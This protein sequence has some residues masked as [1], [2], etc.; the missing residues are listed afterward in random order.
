MPSANTVVVGDCAMRTP[1]ALVWRGRCPLPENRRRGMAGGRPAGCSARI[2]RVVLFDVKFQ[3][4]ATRL[5][6]SAAG[7]AAAHGT[8]MGEVCAAMFSE[9]GADDAIED[10]RNL[11][12]RLSD[13]MRG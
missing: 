12:T 10:P 4:K 13:R 6:V 8:R 7:G 5:A 11:I 1:L 3:V 9:I 2:L